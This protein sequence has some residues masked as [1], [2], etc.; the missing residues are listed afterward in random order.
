MIRSAHPLLQP[1]SPDDGAFTPVQA[2]HLLNRATFGGTADDIA[3]AVKL[4]PVGAVEWLLDFPDAPA[5]EQSKTDV[6]DLS[7]IE[8]YPKTFAERRRL[9]EGLSPQERQD[10]QQRLNNA[11]RQATAEIVRWWLGRMIRG[12]YLMQEKLT[13]LWHG[14]FTSNA[15]DERS[16]WLM[17]R[18]H[19]VLRQHAA[20]NFRSFVHEISRDPAMIDYLNNQQNRKGK[21]N[22]NYARELM[23]LFTLGVGNYSEND[24]KEA[25]KAFTGWGHDGDDYIFRRNF[26]DDGP[27]T[28]FGRTG[29]FNGNDIIDI[30][31]SGDVSPRYIG[32]KV[33]GW[34]AY[35]GVDESLAGA[36]ALAMKQSNYELR[37]LL[38]LILT[39]KAFYSPTAMFNQIKSPVQLLMGTCRQMGI[40]LPDRGQLRGWLDSMGQMPLNP[41]NVKGW[42]GGRTWINT[43]T[44]FARYNACITLAGKIDKDRLIPPGLKS[45]REIVQHWVKTLIQR[46]I[47]E[48][49]LA[50]LIQV[51]NSGDR[52]SIRKVVEL[53]VSMPEY[54]LC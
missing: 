50:S 49:K 54:Q 25:A 33:F 24:I 20:G 47:P 35:E 46:P 4:G 48:D 30:I 52:D 37:P 6:P 22:E 5:D 21:P 14:H 28:F 10:L 9:F 41:P 18:Q 34:L 7:T 44:L 19:E 3:K 42:P 51:A 12:P 13:L 53:I 32:A 1:F 43:S 39:S 15:T 8:G 40:S 29:N 45:P 16:A 11:N 36:L 17:W 2:A 26:H 27:K 23:E 31:L 38:R